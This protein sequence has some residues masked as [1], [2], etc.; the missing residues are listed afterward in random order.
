V[1]AVRARDLGIAIGLLPPGPRNAI[2][3][4]A[5][6]RVGHVTLVQ[7]EGELVVG[8]G[9]VRT[10]VT[11]VVPHD[12]DPFREA[13][14]AGAHRLNGNGELTGLEWIR[15]SGRLTSPIG[16]TN[17]H[18]VGT[19]RD[20]LVAAAYE[21]GREAWSLPVVGETYDGWLNDIDGQHVRP[22][23]VSAA[24]EAASAEVVEGNVG[25]GTGMMCHHF[26]GGIGTASRLLGEDAGGYTVGALVQANYGRRDRLAIDGV[27]IGREIGVDSVPSSWAEPAADP[28]AVAQR[29]AGSIIVILATDAPLLP[30]QC[31][32]LAQR[33]ALGIAR[34]GGGG[35]N[36]SGDLILAFATGN[37]RLPLSDDPDNVPRELSLRAVDDTWLSPLFWAAIESV[38]EAIANALVAAE[39]MTGR[40]G[41]VAYR[42]HHDRLVEVWQ[43]HRGPTAG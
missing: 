11:V 34:S 8:R 9:P 4:V 22:E 38:E 42:L 2:S 12:G 41:H 30:H 33:G 43:R 23:H 24:L 25:G 26:K 37:P 31:R 40:D 36:S 16:L 15:E 13:V 17:T 14:F 10:G 1:A 20:A 19:V 5:G 21:A 39:T 7:G 18:S 35:E 29:D 3:D 27:P 28:A 6:V 32:R